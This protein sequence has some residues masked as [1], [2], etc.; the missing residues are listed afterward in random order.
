MLLKT[1]NIDQNTPNT[2]K[3]VGRYSVLVVFNMFY[4]NARQTSL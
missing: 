3:Q 2:N 4:Y 1:D